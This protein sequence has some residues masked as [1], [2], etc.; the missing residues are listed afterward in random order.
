M[1]QRFPPFR[2]FGPRPSDGQGAEAPAYEAFETLH[3]RLGP[4]GAAG[5][6]AYS[7]LFQRL[8]VVLVSQPGRPVRQPGRRAG[9]RH[10][11]VG[12]HA[13]VGAGAGPRPVF[14][15][16]DEAG[17]HRVAFHV[18]RGSPSGSEADD[19]WTGRAAAY[20]SE[21][22]LSSAPGPPPGQLATAGSPV[23]AQAE[24]GSGPTTSP[25]HPSPGARSAGGDSRP[26][27]RR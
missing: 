23:V 17:P 11:R 8:V 22:P 24:C 1:F 19:G 18:P 16:V 13:A 26:R 4:H 3:E 6:R 25:T 27:S 10:Q 7:Q 14:R 12:S 2:P 21:S 9:V 15:P 5:S 20:L